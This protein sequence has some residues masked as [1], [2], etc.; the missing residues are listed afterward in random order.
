[1][2]KEDQPLT[3]HVEFTGGL[4]LLFL[5]KREHT[6]SIPSIDVTGGATNLASLIQY[7]CENLMSDRRKEMFI[8]DGAVRPG[9]LVLVNDADWELE[10]KEEYQIQRNDNIMFVSTLHGG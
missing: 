9:I 2:P 5:N 6:V 8:L 4:E 1:M 7:L 10:G 3:V